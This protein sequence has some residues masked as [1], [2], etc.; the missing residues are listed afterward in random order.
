MLLFTVGTKTTAIITAITA[1]S[2]SLNFEDVR[3]AFD[4]L[5]ALS[6]FDI[7][8]II[9]IKYPVNIEI[10]I[11]SKYVKRLWETA[12]ST[13]TTVQIMKNTVSGA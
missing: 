6:G 12:R 11:E 4:V 8:S 2:P 9:V 10:F 1:I 3:L 13:T 7:P 5:G